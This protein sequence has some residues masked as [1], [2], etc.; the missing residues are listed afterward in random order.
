MS[1]APS[2]ASGAPRS[3]RIP[4]TVRPRL[5]YLVP[6]VGFAIKKAL[7]LF[8]RNPIAGVKALVWA[9][10]L[11]CAGARK[12]DQLRVRTARLHPS[13]SASEVTA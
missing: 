8:L 10:A 3:T 6:E 12:P 1:S 7:L 5:E 11:M 4:I 2:M 13:Y 9:M